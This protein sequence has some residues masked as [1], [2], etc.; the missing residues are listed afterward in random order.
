MIP[1]AREVPVGVGVT[2][3]VGASPHREALVFGVSGVNP[4]FFTPI[5]PATAGVGLPCSSATDPIQ[6]L[7]REIGNVVGNAWFAS[8][9]AGATT[10]LVIEGSLNGVCDAD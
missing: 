6:L 8:C 2:A 9:P 1:N 3:I 10:I 7:R 5:T 4:V